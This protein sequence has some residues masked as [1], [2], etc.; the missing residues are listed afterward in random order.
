M[1]ILLVELNYQIR[2]SI[3]KVHSLGDSVSGVCSVLST[4]NVPKELPT[5]DCGGAGRVIG[6]VTAPR[7]ETP[8]VAL[9]SA[10]PTP[11]NV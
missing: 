7:S 9:L 11:L 2:R 4:E 1:I 3:P 10:H 5:S 6:S 8:T